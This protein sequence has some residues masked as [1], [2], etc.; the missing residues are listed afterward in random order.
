MVF[1]GVVLAAHIQRA[2]NRCEVAE[3]DHGFEVERLTM[4]HTSIQKPENRSE[5]RF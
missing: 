3:R 5:R 2:I 1:V 4:D